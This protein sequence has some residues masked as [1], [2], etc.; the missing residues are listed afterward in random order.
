VLT[1]AQWGTIVF[2]LIYFALALACLRT[3]L[4]VF[5]GGFLSLMSLSVIYELIFGLPTL[6]S[7]G[8]LR[9][10]VGIAYDRATL[11]ALPLLSVGDFLVFLDY[12]HRHLTPPL[13]EGVLQS[14]GLVLSLMAIVWLGWTDAHLARHFAEAQ[15]VQR[16]M[17][18][19]PFRYV[20]HPR[21][22]GI[23]GG[24]LAFALVFSSPVGWLLL[25][26]WTIV[27]LRRIRLEEGYLRQRFG[28]DYEAYAQL[29]PR[30][31]PGVY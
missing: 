24:R 20:R 5:A 15:A 4:D 22:A 25:I 2:S 11:A 3:R 26:A 21:Y 31:V 7:P 16:I 10:A 29:T 12:G 6:R 18:E 28:R 30:L 9:E 19:G 27:I 1:K 13:W 23:L 8:A 17:Q 14:V